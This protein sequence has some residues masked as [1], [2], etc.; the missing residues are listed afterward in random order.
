MKVSRMQK[1]GSIK[2][3]ADIS[4]SHNMYSLTNA[5]MK[6]KLSTETLTRPGF[7][8]VRYTKYQW[9]EVYLYLGK[10]NLFKLSRE[11]E[12]LHHFAFSTINSDGYLSSERG[13]IWEFD[14]VEPLEWLFC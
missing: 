4:W 7:Y 11:L 1:K 3:P 2:I 9:W 8:Y 14:R 6:Y 5:D 13:E 12:I 10:I